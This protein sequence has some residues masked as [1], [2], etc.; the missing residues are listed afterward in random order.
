MND[1][2]QLIINNKKIQGQ[3]NQTVLEVARNNNIDIPALCYHPDLKIKANCR[4]CLIEIRGQKGLHTSCSTEVKEGMVIDTESKKIN[5]ARKVNL[6]LIF[7]QHR[8]ECHDCIWSFNC[9]LLRLA[10]K[11]NVE[12]TRFVNRK[13]G[14]PVYEF[15]PA[16]IFDS[17]KCIDCGNCI[18]ACKQQSVNF[19]EKE[20]KDHLFEVV[21]T[22]DQK[23][24]CTYCGQCI[25]HCP[26]GA[27]EA[28]GEF[29]DVEKPLQEKDK[30]VIFQFAPSIRTSIGEE[31]DLPYGEV[32]TDK[33]VAAIRRLGVDKVFDVSVGADFTTTEEAR[34]L[35]DKFNKGRGPCLSSC[36]PAWVKFVEFNYPEFIPNLA[37]TRSPQ[38]IIGGLIKT[39]YADKEKLDPKKI[40]VV[41]VMPCVAK[42]Y[43]IRRPELEIN[44][45]KPVDYIL[46]TRELAYLFHKY[47]IDLKNIKPEKADNPL[48][49][50][51]G[52]GVI[53]GVSGG[54]AESAL[55][56]AYAKSTKQKLPKIEF[57][58]LR[59][60]EGIKKAN[61]KIGDKEIKMIVASGLGNARK[62]LEELKKDPKKYDAVEIMACPGGCIGGGGQP[63]PSNSEI[64]KKRA[65]SLYNLD[66]EA[67]V[68]IAHESPIVKEVYDKYLVNDK[69]IHEVC[70][71]SYSQKEREVKLNTS[72]G[73]EGIDAKD[74]DSS[75]T[76]D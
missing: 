21:P 23:R 5:H 72:I 31:F 18:D 33:L 41:S 48:G 59:G 69:I 58:E 56:S 67:D 8:E 10:K 32:V 43:E 27:F 47:K 75:H 25:V 28:V 37:T 12:I 20:E 4:M 19:L 74:R 73:G 46:T 49:V 71:T 45:L 39:Y 17:S 36:C 60:M 30:T 61:I 6:E 66:K 76:K 11:Y 51:S 15:G 52:G 57:D 62:I 13:K 40:V 3:K 42:K 14:F 29:E 7:A 63:V 55:R 2:I 16:L 64:R 9:Q 38:L 68:R 70:H 1:S 22:K 35:L 50:P 53:Y 54:V 24:D 65:Q 44:G 34:E 26:V